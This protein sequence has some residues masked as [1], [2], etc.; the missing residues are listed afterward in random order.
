MDNNGISDKKRLGKIS[1]FKRL[2]QLLTFSFYLLV[3]SFKKRE[4]QLLVFSF[5][6]VL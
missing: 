1:Y 5:Y 6:L 2:L 3:F 4:A